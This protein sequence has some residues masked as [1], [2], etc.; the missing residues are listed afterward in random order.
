MKINDLY[1]NTLLADKINY[2]KAFKRDSQRL[3]F[4]AFINLSDYVTMV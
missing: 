1:Q 3:A 4:S 2:N